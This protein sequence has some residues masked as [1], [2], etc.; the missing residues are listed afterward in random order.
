[1]FRLPDL[2]YGYGALSPVLSERTLRFHHD[3]HHRAYLRTLNSLIKASGEDEALR[4]EALI[5][6]AA[7]RGNQKLFNAAAQSWNHS[8]FWLSMSSSSFRPHGDLGESIEAGFLS[9]S[10]LRDA[11]AAE[12]AAHFGSG[13][14]WLLAEPDGG[15][16]VRA[17]HD[18]HGPVGEAGITPLL[19]CDLWEH[20]YYLDHQDDRRGFLESWFDGLANWEFAERQYASLRGEAEVWTHPAPDSAEAALA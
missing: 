15:L 3:R 9:L 12:G 11:V 2:A 19:V 8:F 16:R 5:V 10:G 18:A 1:M 17:T 7:D 6:Q 20:A 14:V 4:L 13:W